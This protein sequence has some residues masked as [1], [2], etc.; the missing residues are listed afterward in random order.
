MK[1]LCRLGCSWSRNVKGSYQVEQNYCRLALGKKRDKVWSTLKGKAAAKTR[2]ELSHAHRLI[3]GWVL[4]F[5]IGEGESIKRDA[6][7]TMGPAGLQE[8]RQTPEKNQLVSE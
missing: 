1:V 3:C 5:T 2:R 7:S 4:F 8:K 6:S